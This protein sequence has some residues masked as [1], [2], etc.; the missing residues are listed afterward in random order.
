MGVRFRRRTACRGSALQSGGYWRLVGH[1]E[2]FLTFFIEADEKVRVGVGIERAV[3]SNARVRL[4]LTWQIVGAPFS[5]A[6]TDEFYIRLR[7]Y[8]RWAR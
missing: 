2:G 1:A 3:V 6:P 7:L 5:G 8:Q 4:D